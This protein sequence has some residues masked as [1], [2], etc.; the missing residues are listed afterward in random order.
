MSDGYWKLDDRLNKKIEEEAFL[1]S[2]KNG[3]KDDLQNWEEAKNDVMDRI[4]FIAYYL[5]ESNIDKSPLDNWVEAEK[6][7][8]ENF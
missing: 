3:W 7:Y 8:I 6:I 5:H 1:H 2:K 4:R